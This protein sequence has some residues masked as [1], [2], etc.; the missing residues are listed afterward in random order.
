MLGIFI[1]ILTKLVSLPVIGEYFEE[2][3]KYIQE[4]AE[5]T[6]LHRRVRGDECSAA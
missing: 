2:A 5:K 3:E 6:E 1:W 4:Y